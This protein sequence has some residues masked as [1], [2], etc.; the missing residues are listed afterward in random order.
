MSI[1]ARSERELQFRDTK[2]HEEESFSEGDVK[3]ETD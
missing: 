2:G 1:R 3:E